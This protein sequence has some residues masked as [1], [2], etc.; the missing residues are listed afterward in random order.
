MLKN[1][2]RSD[3][4]YSYKHQNRLALGNVERRSKSLAPN[5]VAEKT[6]AFVLADGHKF[7]YIT[8]VP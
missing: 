1:A 8:T 4:S 5:G 7:K 3:L 2:K 6:F